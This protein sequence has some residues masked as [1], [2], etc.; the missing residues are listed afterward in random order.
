MTSEGRTS[1]AVIL[2]ETRAGVRTL[3]LNR[4]ERLNAANDALLLALTA[5]LGGDVSLIGSLPIVNDR[6]GDPAYQSGTHQQ[7]ALHA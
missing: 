4:P 5:A 2:A 7:G 3:T 1:K 6:I